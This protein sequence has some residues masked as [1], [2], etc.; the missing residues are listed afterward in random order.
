MVTMEN[1][2][3]EFYTQDEALQK[4]R[5]EFTI[6]TKKRA[7]LFKHK[8]QYLDKELEKAF[9]HGLKMAGFE[10]DI[11][12]IDELADMI[13]DFDVEKYDMIAFDVQYNSL[14]SAGKRR[15][16]MFEKL[17][18]RAKEGALTMYA[19]DI[20]LPLQPGLWDKG[21]TSRQHKRN[22]FNSRPVK[23][24]ASLDPSIANNKEDYE[25]LN[26]LWM[27]K[28]HKDSTIH[29][30]EWISFAIHTYGK[31]IGEHEEYEGEKIRNFYYGMR[32]SHVGASLIKN[33]IEDERDLL[34]GSIGK[35][36]N[37]D[38][39]R[40]I[41]V[42]VKEPFSWIKFIKH[43]DN[44]IFPYEPLKSDYQIT[45]RLLEALMFYGDKVVFDDR[46]N[47]DIVKFAKD[48]Q[49]WIDKAKESVEK[50]IRLY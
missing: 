30:I 40:K 46:V 41:D 22:V 4:T 6:N 45:L 38:S 9:A 42:R 14:F 23:V 47:K 20:K 2:N 48:K 36:V 28:L 24:L 15:A 34:Y 18:E 26:T 19:C 33:G 12:N 49:L 3:D 27:N 11:I 7:L 43:S 1:V 8:K 32:R 17:F 50:I 16:Y 31:D 39:V 37:I 25:R 13:D 10:V 21:E 44:V 35:S 29:F 5:E